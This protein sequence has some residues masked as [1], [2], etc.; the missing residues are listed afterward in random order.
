MYKFYQKRVE[1]IRSRLWTMLVWLAAAQ[2][3]LLAFV[4][5]E[6]KTKISGSPNDQITMDQPL[7]VLVLA[8]FGIA[9]STYMMHVIDD[10]AGHIEVNWRRADIA[11]GKNNPHV[12]VQDVKLRRGKHPVCRVMAEVAGW[13]RLAQCGLAALA[14]WLLIDS[15]RVHGIPLIGSPDKSVTSQGQSA[16]PAQP[17]AQPTQV[18]PAPK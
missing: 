10:G 16:V 11:L 3:A 7:L 12:V 17:P 18:V 1:T 5:K 6:F 15:W 9:L 2:G 14:I 13:T 8:L 4:V